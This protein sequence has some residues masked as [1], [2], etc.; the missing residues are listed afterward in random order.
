MSLLDP[1]PGLQER[2]QRN[3][4]DILQAATPIIE[5]IAKV[6]P[7][8]WRSMT[9][10]F[11]A[12]ENTFGLG[13]VKVLG[14]GALT[15]LRSL[16]NRA[17]NVFEGFLAPVMVG[18]NNIS[19]QI[20]SVALANQMGATLGA[21]GGGILGFFLGHPGL[22]AVFGGLLGANIESRIRAEAQGAPGISATGGIFG[23]P[24]GFGN[25][26]GVGAD[27]KIT[28]A[29]TNRAIVP[30]AAQNTFS[31]SALAL[32]TSGRRRL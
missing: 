29:S 2:N 5:E 25:I 21:I 23:G 15:P 18:I 26:G 12:L 9:G 22:G 28:F 6:K 19:N 16:Q 7:E 8:T 24:G 13:G 3:L 30:M 17:A 31:G 32:R 20:E 10:L 4:L 27:D 11:T 14:Q 1:I